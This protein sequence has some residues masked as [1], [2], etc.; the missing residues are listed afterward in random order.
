MK[1]FTVKGI[2]TPF[3]IDMLRFDEC[4]PASVEDSGKLSN[5]F[6]FRHGRR[7]RWQLTLIST[8]QDA[9]TVDR[10]LSYSIDVVEDEDVE[11]YKERKIRKKKEQD[12]L[13]HGN[14]PPHSRNKTPLPV[15]NFAVEIE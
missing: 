13:E 12:E 4:W 6:G 10:W 14:R 2:N 9:P 1:K 7:V 3:P 11:T 5:T 15:T 8:R